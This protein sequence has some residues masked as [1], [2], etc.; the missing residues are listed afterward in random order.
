MLGEPS[1]TSNKPTAIRGEFNVV[2]QTC[3]GIK[4]FN[5]NHKII[6]YLK[7]RL[8]FELHGKEG[9]KVKGGLSWYTSLQRPA[10]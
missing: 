9:G 1:Y 8:I 2:M 5:K 3:D 10:I 4:H 7:N 6:N